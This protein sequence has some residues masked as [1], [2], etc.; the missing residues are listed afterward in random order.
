M[1]LWGQ[2][3]VRRASYALVVSALSEVMS[4]YSFMYVISD[5]AGQVYLRI[6]GIIIICLVHILFMYWGMI[7]SSH[8]KKAVVLSVKE[9]YYQ[10][11][12]RIQL[13]QEESRLEIEILRNEHKLVENIEKCLRAHFSRVSKGS[14]FIFS[15]YVLCRIHYVLGISAIML[16]VVFVNIPK[17]FEQRI[18]Q[19]TIAVQTSHN[20][21]LKAMSE[22]LQSCRSG[23]D[24]ASE[25]AYQ[26][27]SEYAT[28][29]LRGERFASRVSAWLLLFNLL[30]S[31]FL[32]VIL[33]YYVMRGEVYVGILL[34]ISGM[35]SNVQT[36]I[37]ESITAQSQYKES[38]AIC[39]TLISQQLSQ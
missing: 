18:L 29:V 19:H 34:P 6:G 32:A 13:E 3:S 9:R 17:V 39:Q 35:L 24:T 15:L 7:L 27:A 8:A 14:V 28:T 11:V 4:L 33:S 21:Y 12:S 5:S 30:S 37:M 2:G 36:G 38:Y 22:L 31:L 1:E 20:H 26:E 10:Q 25:R 16:S 23:Y